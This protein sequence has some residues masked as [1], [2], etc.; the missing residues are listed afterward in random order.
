M[1]LEPKPPGQIVGTTP[2]VTAQT[3]GD[4]SFVLE[5][6]VS[7]G[8]LAQGLRGLQCPQ[9][10]SHTG[11]VAWGGSAGGR[12]ESPGQGRGGHRGQ[13]TPQS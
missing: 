10:T 12:Q 3:H 9:G 2:S 11:I 4:S 6:A 13:D 1:P 5:V 7:P 8:E